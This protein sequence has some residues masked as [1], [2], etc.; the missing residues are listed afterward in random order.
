[1]LSATWTTTA[2][3]CAALLAQPVK[4][5][6]DS[7]KILESEADA[8]NT[9]FHNFIFIICGSVA[10][11]LICWRIL[12][13]SVRYVRLLTC[14]AND[15]QRYFTAPY[16][17]YASLKKHLLYA[18]IFHKRHNREFQLSTAVNMGVLP[19]RF[20]LLFLIAYFAANIAFC[21]TRIHWTESAHVVAIEVRHRSGIL[22]VVN[23]V[24]LFAMSTRNSPL[25]YWLD[26]S[27]DSFNLLH[28]WFGRIVVLET[29]LHTLA[30]LVSTARADG[31][32]DVASLI[33]TDAQVTW[34]VVVS[35]LPFFPSA[36]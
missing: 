1:M 5:S 32:T 10:L 17:K 24:P 26:M 9:L 12:I 28:R 30:W 33:N 15:K 35:T 36:Y 8:V 18:P 29:L 3:V 34:G 16:Q 11:I 7:S 19:T 27:F 31:W 22:A 2:A 23:M 14:L 21:V 25:I 4:G 20:Q 6:A 13:V